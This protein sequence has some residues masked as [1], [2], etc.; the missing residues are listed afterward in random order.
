VRAFRL[1]CCVLYFSSAA[2]QYNDP[3]P[4]VWVLIYSAAAVAV[5][6]PPGGRGARAACGFVATVA[7]VWAGLLLPEASGVALGDLAASMEAKG[8]RVEIAREAG[9]LLLVVG[10]MV[11]ALILDHRSRRAA[12]GD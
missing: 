4:L 11:G 5:L 8:G 10:G 12:E 9:G 2:L 6:L 3:D 1:G 7:L